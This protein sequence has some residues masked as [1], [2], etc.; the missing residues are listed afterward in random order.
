MLVSK[1]ARV[2]HSVGGQK[3]WWN[4]VLVCGLKKCGVYSN[5]HEQEQV[6]STWRGWINAAAEDM[7]EELEAKEQSKKDELKQRREAACHEQTQS[8][9]GCS[10]HGCQFV[11][12]SKAGLVNHVRQKHNRVAQNR[13]RYSHCG[14]LFQKQG[15]TMHK[16]FCNV[17]PARSS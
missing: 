3:R 14:K 8:G 17:N 10:E 2:K 1:L 5:W 12:R 6:H 16:K 4:D 7:N 15:F 13:R 9:W 11:S